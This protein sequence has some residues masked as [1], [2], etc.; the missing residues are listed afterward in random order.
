MPNILKRKLIL[1]LL[2][3]GGIANWE[4]KAMALEGVYLNPAF[5][6]RTEESTT[7]LE[8]G[9]TTYNGTHTLLNIG[10][11][12]GLGNGLLLGLKYFSD[13]LEGRTDTSFNNNPSDPAIIHTTAIGGS[14]GFMVDELS[15]FVSIMAVQ[16]P[17]RED[18]PNDIEYADGSGTMIDGI[19]FADM[20][21]WF[22][23][24]QLTWR[25]FDYKSYKN[26]ED[27][28]DP[29]ADIFISRSES[30]IEPYISIL[31]FF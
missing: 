13:K 8:F 16:A 2:I 14:V 17:K 9:E 11:G 15:F 26:T 30:I 22:L 27:D 25:S 5:S 29:V 31:V 28:N 18:G 20:G 10:L 7:K 1:G 24:P 4:Q 19:Y 21:S 23:G 3:V 12:Y 6:Y